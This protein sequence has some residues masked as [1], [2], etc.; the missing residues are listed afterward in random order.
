MLQPTPHTA[1]TGTT[2]CFI[3]QKRHHGVLLRST[4]GMLHP[5]LC[6]ATTS[7]RQ[8]YNRR[9]VLLPSRNDIVIF[10]TTSVTSCYIQCRVLLQ[11]AA[12][13][14]RAGSAA[15]CDGSATRIFFCWNQGSNLLEPASRIAATVSGGEQ[16]Q[17]YFAATV[18]GI[19][20]DRR[21][22][23]L[24]PAPK[25]GKLRACPWVPWPTTA[26]TGATPPG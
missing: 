20:Y 2:F 1:T 8:C 22:V 4:D 10:A 19:C 21:E 15:R 16:R 17:L 3:A 25:G 12:R 6:F 23:L 11:P 26:A 7:P 9:F 13:R 14:A 18:F 24:R 5:V